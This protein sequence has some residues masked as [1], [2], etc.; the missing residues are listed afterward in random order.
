[1]VVAYARVMPK[2]CTIIGK[3][4]ILYT[5]IFGVAVWLAGALFVDRS[6]TEKARKT[7]QNAVES[8]KRDKAN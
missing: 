4:E 7:I 2:R 8:I 5:G 3:K 1:V 6:N